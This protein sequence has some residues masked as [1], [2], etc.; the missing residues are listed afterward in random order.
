MFN[1]Q[2]N[3]PADQMERGNYSSHGHLHTGNR[4]RKTGHQGA[5]DLTV[6]ATDQTS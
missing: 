2:D 3:V 6:A 1:S 5:S 4:D